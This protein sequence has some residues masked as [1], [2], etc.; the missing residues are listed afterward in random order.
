[1]KK[2]LLT[3]TVLLLLAPVALLA[4]EERKKCEADASDCLREMAQNLKKKGWIG[5]KFDYDEHTEKVTLSK[6][7]DDSPAQRAGMVR[8]DT[9]QSGSHSPF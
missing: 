2:W 7:F 6:V 4:K 3:S 5:I 9:G 1:M 8:D